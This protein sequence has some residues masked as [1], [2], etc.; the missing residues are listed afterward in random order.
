[1]NLNFAEN[2]KN[3]RK[4]KDV[5]QEKIAE[6]LGVSA[7]SISRWELSICY[8]DLELLPSIANYFGVTIDILLSNDTNSKEKD[9][10]VF[11]DTV[12]TFSPKTTEQIDF[13]MEYCRKYPDMDFYACQL[14]WAVHDYAV[15]DKEKTEKYMPLMLKNAQRLLDTQYRFAAI[16][17]MA[18]ISPESELDKWLDMAPYNGFSRRYCL[19]AR[20]QAW[21]DWEMA[22][23]QNG[24]EMFETFVALLDRRFPDKLGSAK[25]LM[26]QRSVLRTIESFGE[27]G[28]VPDGWKMFY[29][30]KQLVLAACLFAQKKTDEGWKNFDSAIEKC[31]YVISLGDEWLDVGG[32]LFSNI[33]VSKNWNYAIDEK[34]DKHELFGPVNISFYNMYYICNLLTDSRWSW[35]NSVRNTEKYQAA[36]E[37]AKMAEEKQKEN[38]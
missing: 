11:C 21:E 16:Q 28:E 17:L 27:D 19:L 36:V 32:R 23:V 2:F 34:G 4:E 20:A 26:F 35:F 29:A 9:F 15:G 5:T 24:L 22:D 6:V 8:P 30:Y 13:V 12:N 33:K 14:L 31:K 10:K 1:M 18:T 7:Q 3:L 37:W 25:K 38:P